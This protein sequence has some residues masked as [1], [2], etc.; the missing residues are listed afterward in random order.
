MTVQPQPM[1]AARD[2]E[3]SSR[4]YQPVLGVESGHG[5]PEYEMLLSGGALTMQLHHWEADEHQHLGDPKLPVGNG[6]LLWFATDDFDAAVARVRQLGAAILDGPLVNPNA[7]QREIWLRDPDGYV[8]VVA[9]P[10]G[11]P[12]E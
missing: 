11:D 7:Q 9:G 3:S 1:I 5:G 6:A 8:V 4:W 2:V 12:G 10:R